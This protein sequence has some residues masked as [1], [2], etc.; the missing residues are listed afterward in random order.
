MS[1]R[2]EFSRKVRAQIILRATNAAGS[3]CCE[4]CGLILGH[5]PYEVD[6]IVA[7]A[8][9]VDKTKPLTADDGQLLGKECCHRGGK[10][11]GDVRQIRK[12]DRQRDKHSGAFKARTKRPMPGSRASGWKRTMD[13]RT[14]RREET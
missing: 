11:A 9:V 1:T 10:T 6:H 13:G 5:K 3:I 8:L 14:I 2:R 12:S 4:G 7:E